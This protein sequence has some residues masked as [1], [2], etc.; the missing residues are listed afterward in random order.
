MAEHQ[1][2]VSEIEKTWGRW[3]LP[4]RWWSYSTVQEIEDCPR[5][6]MLRH[7]DYPDIW[8]RHGY[9]D[10]PNLPAL[11]GDVMH[12][13]LERVIGAM[14]EAGC[15]AAATSA[16]SLVMRQLGGFSAVVTS[17]IDDRL[18]AF[19]D[20]P[21]ARDR[22]DGLREALR[23]RVPQMRQQV[24]AIVAMTDLAPNEGA[25][26]RA[27]STD[28]REPLPPGSH[29]EVELRVPSLGW[30]GR[31]DLI[32]VEDDGCEITDY[33]TGARS[34]RH[35]E[36]IQIYALLWNL[37][38]ELNPSGSVAKRLTL[39]YADG[40]VDIR[41]PS[42]HDLRQLEKAL[43]ERTAQAL[44]DLVDRPPLAKPAPETCSGCPVRHLCPEYWVSLDV[45]PT[46]GDAPAL[47]PGDLE[48]RLAGRTGP[49][50]WEGEVVHGPKRK[51][52]VL[53]RTLSDSAT[54]PL[55]GGVRVLDA[56]IGWDAESETMVTTMTSWTET[57]KV[58]APGQLIRPESAVNQTG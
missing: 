28:R 15:E 25:A 29:P 46:I 33:K 52:R 8:D 14:A 10:R 21:R 13:A 49:K 7:A 42:V 36:Q 31:A 51:A 58:R 1:Q 38:S 4:P 54:F 56:A 40:D 50:S 41:A 47:K 30:V 37:D 5:R 55:R 35:V 32:R 48:V 2:F 24:Q 53:L 39:R 11:T 3:P 43:V 17:C 27:P 45:S 16:A 20:N 23:G 6:W 12:G 34:D 18:A 44:Q 9:P 22:V 19:K 26:F 57:Y